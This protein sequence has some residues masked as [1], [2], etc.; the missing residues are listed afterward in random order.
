MEEEIERLREM[1][2]LVRIRH[3]RLKT[4]SEHYVPWKSQRYITYQSKEEC[5]AM[6]PPASLRRSKAALLSKPG[7]MVGDVI[8][9]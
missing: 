8:V 9:E 1:G 5:A 6:G 3:V 4:P 7:L 2:M